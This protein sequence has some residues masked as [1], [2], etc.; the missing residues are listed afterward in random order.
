LKAQLGPSGCKCSIFQLSNQ[1]R[2]ADLHENSI[3][4]AVEHHTL[5]QYQLA[6]TQNLFMGFIQTETPYYQPNPLAPTPFTVVSSLNDPNFATS[7]SGQSGNCAE[8]WGLRVINSRNVLIYGA[9]HYSFFNN[10]DTSKSRS[11]SLKDQP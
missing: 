2:E 9:G 3:G 6:N 4:T 7:C 8:A 5:Y 10:Y 11:A 1:E